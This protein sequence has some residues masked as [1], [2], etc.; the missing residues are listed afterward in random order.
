MVYRNFP[1][2]SQQLPAMLI[3]AG[4]RGPRLGMVFEN[5]ASGQG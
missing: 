5:N 4:Q 2:D 3:H 1:S